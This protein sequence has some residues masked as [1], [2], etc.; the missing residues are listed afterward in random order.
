VRR[1]L[2]VA[3]AALGL[4]LSPSDFRPEANGRETGPSAGLSNVLAPFAVW[5]EPVLQVIRT[6][7][8]AAQAAVPGQAICTTT[9]YDRFIALAPT[10][11]LE[12]FT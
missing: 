8:Q 3:L 9:G 1:P 11:R 2:I 5:P 12:Q 10:P 6:L 4:L 7:R